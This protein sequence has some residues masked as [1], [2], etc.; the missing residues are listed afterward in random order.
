M[1]DTE[2]REKLRGW[3]SKLEKGL[4]RWLGRYVETAGDKPLSAKRMLTETGRG[5][6]CGGTAFL[7][8]RGESVGGTHPFGLA[9]LCAAGSRGGYLLTGLLLAALTG[10]SDFRYGIVSLLCFLLRF[11]VGRLLSGKQEPLW[12]EPLSIRMAIATA[13][14]FTLGLYGILRSGFDKGK[15]WEAFFLLIALPAAVFLLSG[16]TEGQNASRHRRQAGRLTLL[17]TLILSLGSLSLLGFAPNVMAAFFMTLVLAASGGPSAGCL[18]G[19]IGGL[20]C[21]AS[22]SPMLALC[23]LAAGLLKSRGLIL[24]LLA[25]VGVGGVFSACREGALGIATTLP[26]LLWGGALYLPAARFGLLKRFPSLGLEMPWQEE[27]AVTAIIGAQRDE[28]TRARLASLSEAMSSLAG[29]FYALSHRFATPGTYEVRELCESCFKD[30]CGS[31]RRNGICWGQEYDRTADVLNKLALAVAKNGAAETS[32]LPSDFL[33]RCPH[34]AK[35]LSEITLRHARLLEEA[36]R[37]NKTEIFALDYEALATLLTGASEESAEEY[38]LDEEMTARARKAAIRMGIVWNNVAVFG[39]RRKTLVAGGVEAAGLKLSANELCRHFS[40]ACGTRFTVPEFRI[41]HRYV[42]MTAVSSP[43]I[44]CESA[45]AS[46]RKE[47]ES[48]NG[49]SAVVFENREGYFYSLIS[50][51]MGSGTDAAITSRITCIF[52]EKL[53]SAGNR[54]NTVIKMLNNFIR[55]KNVECFATVDLL[56][57]D[58]LTGDASFIKSGAAASYILRDG[59]LFKLASTSLPIGITREI[60]AEEIRFSLLP[61]DLVIMISDGVSQSFEDGVWLLEHLSD[62]IEPTASLSGI[63]RR[64]L[65]TA[66]EKNQRSDDMTVELVRISEAPPAA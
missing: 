45:R 64:L 1:Q 10:G 9:L 20:A 65:E 14:G 53:L 18:A 30:H 33:G 15:L 26:S 43:I 44:A 24:P 7:L 28:E 37:R 29:V 16:V 36:A 8:A 58:C 52:L 13:G 2:I 49:D 4:S 23:G 32:Q 63:A 3:G 54:K 46:L 17:Y 56:E 61:N 38:R 50:D 27:T 11:L 60:T 62:R 22:D 19:M 39:T 51:G 59:K 25:S 41:Q 40:Q 5:L 35:I 57:I 48:V 42:T 55:N 34:T 12:R 31:C 47:S 6:L 21:H 66:K